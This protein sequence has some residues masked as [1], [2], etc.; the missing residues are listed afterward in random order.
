MTF[1]YAEVKYSRTDGRSW[2]RGYIEHGDNVV[3]E[4]REFVK[5]EL[6]CYKSIDYITV[7]FANRQGSQTLETTTHNWSRTRGWY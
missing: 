4:A 6:L 1:N 3:A 2:E 7:Y 5:T